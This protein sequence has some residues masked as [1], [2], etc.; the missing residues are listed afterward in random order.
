MINQQN[1]QKLHY[2]AIHDDYEAHYFDK[3]SM[4]YRRRYLLKP[5][6]PNDV[7][8]G[9][10]VADLC[11]GSGFNSQLLAKLRPGV[12][13][14]G[15]DLSDRACATYRRQVGCQAHC[16]DLTKPQPALEPFD[17][18]MI[19]GGLHHCVA[20]LDQTL[21]NVAAMLRP[22]AWL[23]LIEPNERFILE[24]I[25]K[26]WYLHDRWFEARTEQALDHDA[27]LEQA[28][29]TFAPEQCRYLGGPAYFLVLNSLI[30]R[31]PRRMK[32]AIVPPLFWLE[33]RYTNLTSNRLFP[34]FGAIWRRTETHAH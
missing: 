23:L 25:R 30:L 34:A 15:F 7:A 3:A 29:G 17:G 1:P 18:A 11:C 24:G 32:R 27:L 9:Q 33:D 8:P 21:T 19:I 4:A 5:L 12:R 31:V 20:D 10:R 28:A 22:G 16:L 14:E 13:T 6:L 26:W 2:Q